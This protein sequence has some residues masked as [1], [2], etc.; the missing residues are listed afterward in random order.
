MTIELKIETENQPDSDDFLIRLDET[1][2]T[3]N[4]A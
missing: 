3:I 2:Q 4:K 1:A